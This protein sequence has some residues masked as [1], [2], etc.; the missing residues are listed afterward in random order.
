MRTTVTHP[1]RV[2]ESTPNGHGVHCIIELRDGTIL[3][4]G[5]S[6]VPVASIERRRL[7]WSVIQKFSNKTVVFCLAEVVYDGDAQTDTFVSG[8]AKGSIKVWSLSSGMRLKSFRAH[9]DQYVSSVVVLT[10]HKN[11]LVSCGSRDSKIQLWSMSDGV[12]VKTLSCDFFTVVSILEILNGTV[13]ASRSN[14]K[15]LRLWD[16]TT[17]NFEC[18]KTIHLGHSGTSFVELQDHSLVTHGYNGSLKLWRYDS[19]STEY[20]LSRVVIEEGLKLQQSSKLVVLKGVMVH[21]KQKSM[22][23]VSSWDGSLR[24]YALDGEPSFIISSAYVNK[25]SSVVELR[26]GTILCGSQN[27]A[28]TRWKVST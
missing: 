5:S 3:S 27:G 9:F 21:L 20:T 13:L 23:A 2:V 28:I 24:G 12:C 16:L 18:F 4:C 8:D 7:D 25:L 19:R 6:C 11:L 17:A 10:K 14:D 22:F 26:D 15:T 1:L